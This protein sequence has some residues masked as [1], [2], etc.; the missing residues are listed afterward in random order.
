MTKTMVLLAYSLL[1]APLAFSQTAELDPE[2]EAI[3]ESGRVRH[4]GRFDLVLNVGMGLV[5][6]LGAGAVMLRQD[7]DGRYRWLAKVEI[8]SLRLRLGYVPDRVAFGVGA[9]PFR[10]PWLATLIKV[11]RVS[12]S[13]HLGIGPEIVFRQR[14]TRNG[15]IAIEERVDL[16]VYFGEADVKGRPYSVLPELKIGLSVRISKSKIRKDAKQ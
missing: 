7:A 12:Y 14:V 11:G 1:A 3:I 8:E 15:R 10:K 16:P 5:H 4:G 6:N 13:D 9:Y 2:S